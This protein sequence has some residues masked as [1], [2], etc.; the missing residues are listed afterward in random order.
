M[1]PRTIWPF[2]NCTRNIV[3][4]K[5]VMIL[6]SNSMASPSVGVET[7]A[8]VVLFSVDRIVFRTAVRRVSNSWQDLELRRYLSLA[9]PGYARAVFA[10]LA[11]VMF[12]RKKLL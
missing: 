1:C 9:S 8:W 6:P 2:A 5:T 4:G 10:L 3:P 7:G 12:Q 11:G